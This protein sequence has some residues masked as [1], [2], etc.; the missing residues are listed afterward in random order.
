LPF[1]SSFNSTGNN[2][3]EGLQNANEHL[4]FIATDLDNS[5]FVNIPHLVSETYGSLSFDRWSSIKHF[6]EDPELGVVR[7][8]EEHSG[9]AGMTMYILPVELNE[10]INGNPAR[11]TILS[12]DNCP[13]RIICAVSFPAMII[14]FHPL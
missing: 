13:F 9:P 10:E 3:H 7:L 6:F 2:Y 12:S 4:S 14:P 1:I 8:S 5:L 11:Y